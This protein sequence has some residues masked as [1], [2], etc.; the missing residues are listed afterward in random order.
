MSLRQRARDRWAVRSTASFSQALLRK[1]DNRPYVT[2]GNIVNLA[3]N[4]RFGWWTCRRIDL[5]RHKISDREPRKAFHT[6]RVRSRNF[7]AVSSVA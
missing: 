4:D 3:I 7:V 2:V 5:A 6:A 1:R